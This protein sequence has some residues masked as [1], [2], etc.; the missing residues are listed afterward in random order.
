MCI[1]IRRISNTQENVLKYNF[2]NT[3]KP[4]VQYEDKNLK[5]CL[6]T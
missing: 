4:I 3:F 2:F 6:N 1:K 5:N